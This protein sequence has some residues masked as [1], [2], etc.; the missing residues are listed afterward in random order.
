MLGCRRRYHGPVHR[1]FLPLPSAFPSS[2][3]HRPGAERHQ[4]AF[5]ARSTGRSP[6]ATTRPR[7]L[8]I[9]SRLRLPVSNRGPHPSQTSVL[10]PILLFTRLR[11]VYTR[12]R[13]LSARP[14]PLC[15]RLRFPFTRSGPCPPVPNLCSP[16]PDFFPPVSDTCP[17]VPD[18][19]PLGLD[20]YVSAPYLCLPIPDHVYPSQTSAHQSQTSVDP[21]QTCI[22]PSQTSVHQP[23]ASVYPYRTEAPTCLK[24]LSTHLILLSARPRPLSVQPADG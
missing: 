4:S 16:V 13:P 9:S 14:R 5:R 12:P 19:H 3:H 8:P 7:P 21:R 11:H 1:L 18:L 17:P 23:Q 24:H 6:G 2:F 10:R 15:V 20:R 22:C